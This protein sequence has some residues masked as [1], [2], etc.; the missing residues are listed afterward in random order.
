MSH[1]QIM[2]LAWLIT[3]G[4]PTAIS[5]STLTDHVRL[6]VEYNTNATYNEPRYFNRTKWSLHERCAHSA[7][8]TQTHIQTPRLAHRHIHASTVACPNLNSWVSR[9]TFFIGFGFGFHT[10]WD[11]FI[12]CDSNSRPLVIIIDEKNE[13]IFYFDF[14][15]ED[16]LST[17]G[18][19]G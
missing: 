4:E 17:K 10:K 12:G 16:R 5:Q 1:L 19:C 9:Q 8:Q 3:S 15:A 13:D 18:W 11:Y 7:I 2:F 6:G 14:G